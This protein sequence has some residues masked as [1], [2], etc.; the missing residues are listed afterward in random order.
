MSSA[1]TTGTVPAGG[2]GSAGTGAFGSLLEPVTGV[3]ATTFDALPP[4]AQ[5]AVLARVAPERLRT[6][7]AE[8][9]EAVLVVTQTGANTLAA[10]QDLVLAAAVRAEELAIA[11]L[12]DDPGDGSDYAPDAQQVVASAVASIFHVAP[13]SMALR[14]G[15]A[16]KVVDDLP[17]TL[18]AALRGRLEPARVAIIA[19]GALDVA[20]AVAFDFDVVLHADP[21]MLDMVP[22][23]LRRAVER[24]AEVVDEDAFAQRAESAV[25][26]RFVTARPGVEVGMADWAA[27]LRAEDSARAWAAID[28]LAQEYV[29]QGD[30]SMDQARADAFVDLLLGHAR[31]ETV[32]ELVVPTFTS[33][34]GAAP[35]SPRSDGVPTDAPMTDG[36]ASDWTGSETADPSSA[37][38]GSAH[39]GS[40][41][42]AAAS[43]SSGVAAGVAPGVGG[44]TGESSDPV[45]E[46]EP[47]QPIPSWPVVGPPDAFG[48]PVPV[49][50]EHLLPLASFFQIGSE[51]APRPSDGM[52][53]PDDPRRDWWWRPPRLGVRDPRHGWVLAAA[54]ADLL[55]DPD[56]R[57]R[58]TRADALTGV[59]VARDP[60]V[61]RPNRALAARIRDRDR[62]CRFPGCTVAAR[63]CDIDH[64]V[65]FPEGPTVEEDL[66]CL[67]RTHHGFKHHAGWQVR[68][69]P[70]GTCHWLSPYGRVLTSEPADLR[71]DAA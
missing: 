56:V 54:L 64:V 40:T 58:I 21:A 48:A 1:A 10:V 41:P 16:C 39:D 27:S 19:E 2:S 22:G 11:G 53:A 31:V 44:A 25:R 32:V 15:R 51:L 68:L 33:P 24:A 38:D 57:I 20:H 62:T 47:V 52:L 42:D 61:Y 37:A 66:M 28:A 55:T 23:R 3:P 29:Q 70:D 13:R 63:R 36:A 67:C 60:R 46:F 8:T 43:G 50:I 14:V 4:V 17:L 12:N 59:T 26:G 45:L 6:L 35:E 7:D 30:R 69:E 34:S 5:A 49:P 9:S 65:R 18:A 71:L